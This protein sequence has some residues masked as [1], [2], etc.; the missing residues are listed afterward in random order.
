[1][2]SQPGIR[3]IEPILSKE[4]WAFFIGQK[5]RQKEVLKMIEGV[6]TAST[7]NQSHPEAVQPKVGAPVETTPDV[8]EGKVVQGDL[9]KWD[10]HS[11][12]YAACEMV[13]ARQP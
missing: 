7:A 10:S 1:M 2:P 11:G 8:V 3:L 5:R 12:R 4:E 13:I 6:A 9:I